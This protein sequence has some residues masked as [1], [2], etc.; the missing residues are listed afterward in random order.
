M[1]NYAVQLEGVGKQYHIA[2]VHRGETLAEQLMNTIKGPFRR[3]GKLLSGQQTGAAELDEIFWALRDITFDV[4]H[5]E[6]VGIIGKNGAGKSTLLKLLSHITYPTEGRISLYGRVGS[7][8][9]VGTGFHPELTGRENVYMNGTILGMTKRDV[10]SKFDE[11]VAFSGVERFIDTPTKHYS[12]GMKLRLAFAV[13]AHLEPEI[14]IVDEVLAVGDA[15]FQRK[16]IG[17]MNDVAS[18]GRTVLF[19]SH[20]LPMIRQLCERGILLDKGRII[21]DNTAENTLSAYINNEQAIDG[22]RIWENGIANDGVDEFRIH[23]VRILNDKREISAS[24]DYTKPYT[25][26]IDYEIHEP[27]SPLRVG[28]FIQSSLGIDVLYAFDADNPEYNVVRTPGYYTTQCT[29]P[30]HLIAPG[31]YSLSVNAGMINIRNLC[32]LQSVLSL[33]LVETFRADPNQRRSRPGLISPKLD[34]NVREY[35]PVI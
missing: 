34:W 23:A 30:G 9:E 26:E 12:S 11:I 7:L 10:D 33:N 20:N 25:I 16:S 35:D 31:Q 24:V 22:Q 15:D 29:I 21:H 8:L 5:G 19:V 18:E 32:F 17:K 1:S 2:T 28:F 6:V 3:A 13:A 27:L 14:L 4:K